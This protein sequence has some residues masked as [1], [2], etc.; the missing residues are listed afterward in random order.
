MKDGAVAADA[1]SAWVPSMASKANRAQNT[2]NP[3]RANLMSIFERFIP[4]LSCC[5][6][7]LL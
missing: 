4:V 2:N 1:G 6:H 3:R 5:Y 7:L